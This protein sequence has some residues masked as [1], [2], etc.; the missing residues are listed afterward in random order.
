MLN[1]PSPAHLER[2]RQ[3]LAQEAAVGGADEHAPTPAGRVYDKLTAQ[4]APLVG[5][6]GLQLLFVRSAKLAQRE[7][8]W[9]AEVSILEGSAKLRSCLGAHDPPVATESAAALFGIF[10][11][12][13]TTF[14]GEQLTNQV[15]RRA[16]PTLDETV[17]METKK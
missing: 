1:R 14:I 10:F 2:A 4:L 17:P 3:L 8:A 13:I 15:L 9:F 6:T 5:D 11:E 16:W 12:L 7:F